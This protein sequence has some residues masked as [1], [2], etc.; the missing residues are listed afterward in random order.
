MRIFGATV[1][2]AAFA[3][4]LALAAPAPPVAAP[5]LKTF[6]ASSEVAAL[7]A[8]AAS[9]RKD[10]VFLQAKPIIGLAPY[11]ANLEY[12]TGVAPAAIHETEAEIFYVIDGSGVLTTGGK[13]A[14]ET[15]QNAENLRGTG[16]DGGTSRPVAKGDFYV[17][18]EGVPHW[19]SRI[20]GKLVL[21]SLHVPHQMGNPR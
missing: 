17:I 14:G 11:V 3:A 6:A 7:I 5:P 4:S 2:G 16:I 19:Y 10:G 21:M 15:R 18:P 9:E 1:V 8:Q 20:N 13:L 12:R